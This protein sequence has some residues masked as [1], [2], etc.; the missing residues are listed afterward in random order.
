VLRG[1]LLDV[2]VLHP[3]ARA[4]F[5]FEIERAARFDAWGRAMRAGECR[6]RTY[7]VVVMMLLL[8]YHT[9]TPTFFRFVVATASHTL[10]RLGVE[11]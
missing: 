1:V 4:F 6:L 9:R 11:G 10:L 2:R 5:V 3:Y 8:V 7:V